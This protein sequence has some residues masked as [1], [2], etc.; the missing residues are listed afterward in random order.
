M[1]KHILIPAAAVLLG[2]AG[3]AL[4]RWE[5]ATAFDPVS[6]LAAPGAP[7][8]LALVVFSAAVALLC[9]ALGWTRR[10]TDYGD[11]DAAFSAP[12]CTLGIGAAVLS[13]FLL[14]GAAGLEAFSAPGAYREAAALAEE[15]G[16]SNPA[17]A[18]LLPLLMA[19]LSAAAGCC[20]LAVGRKCYRAYREAAA[21]AEEGGGSNPALALLLPLLMAGLSAAAGCCVL[22]VGRKCYRG[23]SVG[24]YSGL[25][26]TPAYLCC[27]W[28]VAAY[29]SRA[30]DPVVQDYLYELLAIIC[31]LL[32]VYYLA[33]FSF[34]T[35]KAGRALCFSLLSVYFCM[36]TL[37][38]GHDWASAALYGF[39]ILY[40]LT[41]SARLLS[42]TG[43][44]RA[45]GETA[46]QEHKTEGDPNEG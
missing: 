43:K 35:P 2:G 3:F 4:R 28:L 9:A 39:G 37:A 25:L 27:V 29:Q 12:G 13:A 42:K 44:P 32:S 1:R 11:Y 18:L 6:G 7:A 40:P 20:V 24:K 15:G 16:G 41:L 45:A 22:A 10:N 5:L 31:L 26:L 21:L 14:L 17:L 33:G 46:G 23:E 30:A 8:T 34:E 36:T 19:G 38:D